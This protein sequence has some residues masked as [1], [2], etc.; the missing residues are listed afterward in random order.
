MD[1][2]IEPPLRGP[3]HTLRLEIDHWDPE[4]R[5]WF[6]LNGVLLETRNPDGST[7]SQTMD[8]SRHTFVYDESGRLVETQVRDDGALLLTLRR[9]YD[10]DG[11]LA[12]TVGI[13]ADGATELQEQVSYDMFGRR[14]R[15]RFV[16]EPARMEVAAF[17]FEPQ[18]YPPTVPDRGTLTIRHDDD[19]RPIEELGHNAVHELVSRRTYDYDREGRLLRDETWIMPDSMQQH[20]SDVITLDG[21]PGFTEGLLSGSTYAYDARGRL[22]E[23]RETLFGGHMEVVTRFRYDDRGFLV[24]HTTETVERLPPASSAGDQERR[25]LQYRFDYRLDSHGNWI[26]RIAS[27]RDDPG[28]TSCRPPASAG[29]SAISETGR[30]FRTRPSHSAPEPL[31]VPIHLV[32]REP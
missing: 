4:R 9:M 16:G 25:F 26:E 23:R 17:L 12:E 29:R 10:G 8:R 20:E 18:D 31:P 2:A 21:V 13:A 24:E 3:V 14:I 7:A 11:R 28:A 19:D 30:P 27:L 1:I 6:S 15:V 22:A 32:D 5:E